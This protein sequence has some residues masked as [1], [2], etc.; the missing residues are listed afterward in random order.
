MSSFRE[1]FAILHV[2]NAERARAFYCDELG[3]E[4]T[5]R[6]PA[7]GEPG[8]VAVRLDDFKLGLTRSEEGRGAA[9]WLYCDDVD[10]EVER[11]RAQGVRVLAEP[12]S[13]PWG[14]RMATVADPDGT[15]IHLGAVDSAAARSS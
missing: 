8:Y 13:M 9:L 1:G 6:W 14:E 5:Y 11:L 2:A 10:A 12:E 15:Q 3:F 7:E 4:E